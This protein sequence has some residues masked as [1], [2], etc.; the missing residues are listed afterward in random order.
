MK[1]KGERTIEDWACGFLGRREHTRKELFL[2]LRKRGF[3]AGDI[4]FTLKKLEEAGLQDDSRFA[5]R[6]LEQALEK[7]TLGRSRLVA[8]L[9]KRGVEAGLARDVVEDEYPRD[10]EAGRL[11]QTALNQ[12]RKKGLRRIEEALSRVG[13]FLARKGFHEEEIYKTLRRVM[14]QDQSLED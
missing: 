6:W 14:E 3:A 13:P 10:E 11:Y 5:R 9:M 2:K 8:E 12:V 7:K 1:N 4:D